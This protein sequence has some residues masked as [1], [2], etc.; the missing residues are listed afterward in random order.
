MF[1]ALDEII[2]YLDTPELFWSVFL[3]FD[4]GEFYASGDRS[5]DP[6]ETFTRPE[7]ARIVRERGLN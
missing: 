2:A 6:I 7:I 3:A 1:S 4:A 5:I